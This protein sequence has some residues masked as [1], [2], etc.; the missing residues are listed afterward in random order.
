MRPRCRREYRWQSTAAAPTG[1]VAQPSC[2]RQL[3]EG[4]GSTFS[5][6]C[7]A[8][9]F[10]T[11]NGETLP[12]AGAATTA[13][14]PRRAGGAP[15]ALRSSSQSGTAGVSTEMSSEAQKSFGG[16]PPLRQ[17]AWAVGGRAGGEASSPAA[18]WGG[19]SGEL[20]GRCSSLPELWRGSGGAGA[21]LVDSVVVVVGL[22]VAGRGGEERLEQVDLAEDPDVLVPEGAHCGGRGE[23]TGARV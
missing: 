21:R 16:W 6:V 22:L 8:A 7:A 23:H 19:P 4:V 12:G 2:L 13:P 18:G 10:A 17:I 3:S 20:V 9:R 5:P 11:G 15:V 1:S 14:R